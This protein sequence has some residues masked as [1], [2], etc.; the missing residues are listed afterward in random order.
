VGRRGNRTPNPERLGDHARD[1]ARLLMAFPRN[2][3][4]VGDDPRELVDRVVLQAQE[5]DRGV[6]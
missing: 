3:D 2:V 6:E 4:S 5:A 1:L